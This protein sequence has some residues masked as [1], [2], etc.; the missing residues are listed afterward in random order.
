MDD[1]RSR[2]HERIAEGLKET[3]EFLAQYPGLPVLVGLGLIV[4]NFLFQLL[5]AW[6]VLGW[7]AQVDLLLHL[8]LIISLIGLLLVRAL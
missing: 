5:P 4:L 3:T 6:P 1:R 7:I 8:G 2:T